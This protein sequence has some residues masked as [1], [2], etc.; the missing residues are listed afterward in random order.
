MKRIIK[1]GVTGKMLDDAIKAD[2]DLFAHIPSEGD[3]VQKLAKKAAK[4]R[5]EAS[6][7]GRRMAEA[8]IAR[9]CRVKTGR[10]RYGETYFYVE[11]I[12]EDGSI[13]RERTNP[14]GI[15]G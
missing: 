12:H 14:D 5:S 7:I 8:E 3:W 15:S 1:K 2:P 13:T 11:H 4:K 6:L 10:D 9:R